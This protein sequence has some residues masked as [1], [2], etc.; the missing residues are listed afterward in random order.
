M[1]GHELVDVEPHRPRAA[2]LVVTLEI[3]RLLAADDLAPFINE[4]SVHLGR[5]GRPCVEDQAVALQGV[6]E[7]QCAPAFHPG[8][9][10]FP[11]GQSPPHEAPDLVVAVDDEIVV[12]T[13]NLTDEDAGPTAKPQVCKGGFGHEVFCGHAQRGIGVS[14]PE[15]SEPCVA[16][17]KIEGPGGARV[18]RRGRGAFPSRRC[19]VLRIDPLRLPR[20]QTAGL[21]EFGDQRRQRRRIGPPAAEAARIHRLAHLGAADRAHAAVG[22][23]KALAGR[24]V[25]QIEMRQ[26]P[27]QRG[28]EIR[29]PSRRA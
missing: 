5:V 24:I 13:M 14:R 26:H 3:E 23:V 12:T 9:R 28:V 2:V 15:Q 1:G 17:D 7:R 6:L 10:N 4:K 11:G 29:R 22:F 18:V 20:R 19:F 8:F 21:F 27:R 25:R 16:R